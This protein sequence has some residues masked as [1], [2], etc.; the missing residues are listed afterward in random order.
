MASPRSSRTFAAASSALNLVRRTRAAAAF[1]FA[2]FFFA[3]SRFMSLP[4]KV[5]RQAEVARSVS[6]V[7]SRPGTLQAQSERFSGDSGTAD[8]ARNLG[9][10][11]DSAR[12]ISRA[13]R[14]RVR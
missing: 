2:V 4:L 6:C 14:V 3:F 13:F 11:C 7:T 9:K 12:D 1:D 8:E 5:L 10:K